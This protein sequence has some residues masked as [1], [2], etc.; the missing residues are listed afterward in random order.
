MRYTFYILLIYF[1][2]L[3]SQTSPHEI[4]NLMGRGIN[5]GNVLSAP[6]EGNWAHA[7]YEDYFVQ[8]S[9]AGFTNVRIPVD[10]YSGGFLNPDYSING[11]ERSNINIEGCT[12]NNC[13]SSE[14]NTFSNYEGSLDDYS[15]NEDYLDRVQQIV[16]WAITYNIIVVLDFH[17]NNL[18]QEFV[19]TFEN[20]EINGVNY[21][22]NPTS[23]KRLADINRFKSIWRDI[24]NRFK[25]Y[26]TNS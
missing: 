3:I 26:S 12:S 4:V 7:V 19:Y 2:P 10:F 23:A 16:D 9:E 15:V 18:K 14:A 24:S 8:L 1:N 11:S 25:D 5:M 20:E 17:G 13:F 6:T 22:T 21:Y